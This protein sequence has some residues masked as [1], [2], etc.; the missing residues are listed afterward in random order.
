MARIAY[1]P[2]DATMAAIFAAL[3]IN[4]STADFGGVTGWA[5]GDYSAARAAAQEAL[6]DYDEL[7]YD[8]DGVD[9][10]DAVIELLEGKY[11]INYWSSESGSMPS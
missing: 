3:N 8:G 10:L 2:Y 1:V 5:A 6:W 7:D 4:I 11:T 9:D